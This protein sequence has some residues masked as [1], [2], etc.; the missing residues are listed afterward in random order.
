VRW[1]HKT[2]CCSG[3][4]S[5][6]RPD[7]ARALVGNIIE[8]ARRGGAG[9]VVTDCPMCQANLDSRQIDENESGR[10][11]LPVFFVTEL[12]TL[13]LS[14]KERP[15]RWKAHLVDPGPLLRE[16]DLQASPSE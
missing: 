15:R 16:L 3:S 12:M 6:T 13:A 1:S 9:A 4:L 8:A 14:T 10:P 7:I 11:R 2:E 5:M